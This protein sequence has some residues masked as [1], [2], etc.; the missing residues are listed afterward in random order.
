MRLE[1]YLEREADN[2]RE[3]GL[4]NR[5]PEDYRRFFLLQNIVNVPG[6]AGS[7]HELR[8]RGIKAV[9]DLEIGLNKRSEAHRLDYLDLEGEIPEDHRVMQPGGLNFTN[10]LQ[11]GMRDED[12]EFLEREDV[13]EFIKDLGLDNSDEEEDDRDAGAGAAATTKPRREFN[14]KKTAFLAGAP[15][16]FT[17]LSRDELEF[18]F[19]S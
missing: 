17:K 10:G 4:T 12:R 11:R 8:S 7:V 6:I 9:C 16:I 2:Y 13:Q 14:P 5:S 1:T 19:D 18:L 15:Q 3:N